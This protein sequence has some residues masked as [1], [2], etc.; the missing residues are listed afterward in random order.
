M[1]SDALSVSVADFNPGLDE[2]GTHALRVVDALVSAL[3]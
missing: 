2:H 1:T 3:E